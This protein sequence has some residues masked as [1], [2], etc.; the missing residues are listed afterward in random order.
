MLTVRKNLLLLGLLTIV[1]GCHSD[2]PHDYGEQRPPVGQLHPDDR[3]LQ[4]KDVIEASDR[5]AT[6]LLALPELNAA[7]RQWTV[8]VDRVE[9]MTAN[10]GMNYDIWVE[11]LKV[12]VAREGRG[13]VRLI[14]NK[15][16]FTD[17][18]NRELENPREGFGQGDP[19]GR[20]Q[21]NFALYGKIMEMTNRATS[22]YLCEFA[23]TDLRTREMVWTNAYEVKVAR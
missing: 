11:R 22:Y 23:L 1:A 6:D 7:G 21:P 12:N 17:L 13:R 4:S 14:E 20:I 10:P 3:G 16:R 5:L 19:S 8:V 18:R 15:A 2:R 9:N